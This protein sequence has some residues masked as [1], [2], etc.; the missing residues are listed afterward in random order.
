MRKAIPCDPKLALTLHFLATGSNYFTLHT[1][2]QVG[3][4]TA[5]EITHDV[6]KAIWDV[7]SPIYLRLPTTEDWKAVA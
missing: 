7:L 2:F 1:H 5:A 3:E 6:C 4:S